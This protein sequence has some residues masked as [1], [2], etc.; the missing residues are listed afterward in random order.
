MRTPP[1]ALIDGSRAD[2]WLDVAAAVI[3]GGN[4]VGRILG[5]GKLNTVADPSV[6]M[7]VIKAGTT[8]GITEGVITAVSGSEVRIEVPFEYPSKDYVLSEEGDSGSLWIDTAT[9]SPVGLHFQGAEAG[10]ETAFARPLPAVFA[11][12]GLRLVVD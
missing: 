10:L 4:A 3:P 12:L 1:V 5:L 9:M 8:T 11:A 2:Q 7:R 6:G